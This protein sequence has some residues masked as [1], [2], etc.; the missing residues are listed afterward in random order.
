MSYI[1]DALRKSDQ[2]RQRGAAPT[3]Q[4]VQFAAIPPE[5]RARW[6]YVMLALVLAGAAFTIGWLRPWQ[7]E[8]P[9]AQAKTV[10]PPRLDAKSSETLIA[11]RSLVAQTPAEPSLHE[12]ASSAPTVA[13]PSVDAKPGETLIPTRSVVAQTPA[14]SSPHEPA[15]TKPRVKPHASPTARGKPPAPAAREASR[16][17]LAETVKS[18]PQTTA[19]PAP[20]ATAQE[21]KVVALAELP[22][23]VRQQLP[24][25]TITVHAYS[26][27]PKDRLVGVNDKLLHEGESLTPEIVLEKITPDGMVFNFKG[28][29]FQRGVQ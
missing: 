20:T 27:T 29:R 15:T 2:Q 12:P 18:A 22:A 24:P 13:Q 19:D 6:H 1:L 28:T 3:L 21:E 11:T 26:R 7:T 5:P 8:P 4:S 10:P 17:A 16:T 25:M 14:E 9:L 23:S